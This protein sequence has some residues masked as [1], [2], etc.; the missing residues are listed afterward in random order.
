MRHEI[1]KVVQIVL[2]FFAVLVALLM[3]SRIPYP[4]VV[5]QVFR[6][7]RS[8]G[9]VVGLLFAAVAIMSIHGYSVP[10]IGCAV[11]ARGAGQVSVAAVVPT[12]RNARSDLLNS[13]DAACSPDSCNALAS[14]RAGRDSCRRASGS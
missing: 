9:H 11:R 14:V 7:Q 13:R 8:F 3:V 4:H 12:A 10:I 2:P 1:D 5:N 6:G